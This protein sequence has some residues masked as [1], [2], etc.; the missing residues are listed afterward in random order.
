MREVEGLLAQRD[1]T[2]LEPLCVPTGHKASADDMSSYRD[3]S[4]G[5]KHGHGRTCRILLCLSERSE[6]LP[7][8]SFQCK[9]H[10][11]YPRGDD[12]PKTRLGWQRPCRQK[13]CSLGLPG[14]AT[15]GL[16]S[17]VLMCESCLCVRDFRKWPRRCRT[18]RTREKNLL[19]KAIMSGVIGMHLCA[20]DAREKSDPS[21]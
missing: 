5:K 9:T 21:L 18:H 2:Q 16:T 15:Q 19:D 10:T 1:Q 13:G 8:V 7:K 17:R 6:L 20:G 11:Q 12:W 3:V 14:S 4:Q